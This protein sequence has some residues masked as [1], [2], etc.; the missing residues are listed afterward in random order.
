MKQTASIRQRHTFILSLMLFAQLRAAAAG[1]LLRGP[2]EA[3]EGFAAPL[4]GLLACTQR[5]QIWTCK[6]PN[7]GAVAY[8]E[9]EPCP[10]CHDTAS[11]EQSAGVTLHC[12]WRAPLPQLWQDVMGRKAQLL[13]P[14]AHAAWPL[15]ATRKILHCSQSGRSLQGTQLLE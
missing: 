7:E 14:Q 2:L 11:T 15:A 8:A 13:C 1:L 3:E 9:P 6:Y 4:L 10:C 12:S 5:S